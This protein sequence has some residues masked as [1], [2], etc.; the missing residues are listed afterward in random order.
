MNNG[1]KQ[2]GVISAQLFPVYI[3]KLLLD[4]KHSGY[5]CHLGDTITGVLSYADDITLN[6]FSLR[7]VDCML[8]ICSDLQKIFR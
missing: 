6:C 2:G 8:K 1:V 7:G 3:D 5:G 4:L